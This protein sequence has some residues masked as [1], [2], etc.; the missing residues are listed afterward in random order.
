MNLIKA[1]R[2]WRQ[3][4]KIVLADLTAVPLQFIVHS[5]VERYRIANYGDERDVLEHFL[6]LLR[7][8][9]VVYDIG[10]SIGLYAVAAAT[11]LPQGRLYA[12]EP[13]PETCAA[14]QKNVALNHLNNVETVSWAVSD[15]A[16]S[17]TLFTDGV[18]GFAPS[19]SK[20]ER[21]NAPSGTHQVATKS[22]D[23]A[24]AENELRPAT[25]IKLDIEGAEMLAFQGGQ[26]LLDGKWGPP[27]R[28]IF[29]EL[30]PL[31]LPDFGS[32]AAEV[33]SLLAN[34]GYQLVWS[35]IRD[36]QEHLFYEHVG[37]E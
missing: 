8:D 10:A 33:K 34:S 12:F 29:L 20:Q 23:Q 32:T 37:N 28:L 9:D 31:F 4:Q 19:L 13:D 27:P 7:P 30:H 17:L 25:V 14:L 5:P 11:E 15:K 26:Q 18:A 3:R 6:S 1:L 21:P 35:D 22:L 16:G 2:R 24:L 36:D